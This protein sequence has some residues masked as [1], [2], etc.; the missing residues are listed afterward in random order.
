MGFNFKKPFNRNK[1]KEGMVQGRSVGGTVADIVIILVLCIVAFICLVPMW[2]VLM[3]SLYSDPEKLITEEGITWWFG[4]SVN[5]EAYKILFTETGGTFEQGNILRGMVN[6]IVYM[7]VNVVYGLVINVFAG[8][9]LSRNTK[10]RKPMTMFCMLSLVFSAGTIP[11]YIVLR[12]L[13]M[14]GTIWSLVLPMCTNGMFMVLAMNAFLGVPEATVEA[15]RIDGAGHLKTMFMVMLPQAMGLITVIM[16]NTAILHWNSWF[17]ASIYIP[18]DRD[19]W[20]MQLWVR[21]IVANNG[22]YF[23]QDS[24]TG[25]FPWN[26][27]L[28]QFAVIIVST[29]PILVAFPFFYKKLEK[30]SIAGAVKG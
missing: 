16:I 21:D 10:L 14:T 12:T 18:N 13:G 27:Y 22:D 26:K 17:Q 23:I 3:S 5:F 8:Y 19:L 2:H 20:P 25:Q 6:T 29:I 24:I 9:C 28:L 1:V 11:T 4:S 15:A 30:N 7:L